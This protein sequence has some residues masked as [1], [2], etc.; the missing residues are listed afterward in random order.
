LF[1]GTGRSGSTLV[2]SLFDAHPQIIMAHE[3]HALK[4]IQAGFSRNQLYHLLLENS[5]VYAANGRQAGGYQYAVEDR[6]QGK[7]DRLQVI[8][9]K[10]ATGA[11][12]KLHA[13][14]DL[15]PKL[16]R[17]TGDKVRLIHVVRNP[18]DN[19]ASKARAKK[20]T[21]GDSIDP[22]FQN[23]QTV[24]DIRDTIGA[25]SDL[26]IEMISVRH[27]ELVAAPQDQLRRLCDFLGLDSPSDYLEACAAIV[28]KSPNKARFSVEWT[29][30]QIRQVAEEL[31][32]FPFLKDYSYDS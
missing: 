19:I 4:Y 3:L 2:G 22:Y 1:V 5:R 30:E 27:D 13:R 9:D 16:A 11:A 26:D 15:L 21:V 18:Y 23:C 7:F 31:A 17:V 8:G 29:P 6:W 14:P 24:M 28:H 10:K 32:R 20:Q 12:K 25:N